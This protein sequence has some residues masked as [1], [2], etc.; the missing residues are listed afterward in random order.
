MYVSTKMRA[1]DSDPID[2]N[3]NNVIGIYVVNWR[4][5]GVV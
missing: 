2:R 3:S 4:V 5:V 1:G